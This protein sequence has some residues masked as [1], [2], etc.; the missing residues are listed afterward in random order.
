M[1][2]GAVTCYSKCYLRSTLGAGDRTQLRNRT[3]AQTQ[4]L[5]RI[6]NDMKRLFQIGIWTLTSIGCFGQPK[7]S[8]VITS[9][10]DI[11]RHLVENKSINGVEYEFQDR[12]HDSYLDTTS[13]TITL[14][15]RGLSKNGKWLD[16]KG[17]VIF[18]DL[19]ARKI[20]WRKTLNYNIT[21]IEQ[22]NSLIIETTAAKSYSL[23][24][25][26][27]SPQWEI[28]NS[29]YY[30]D[31]VNSIGLGYE[32]QNSVKKFSNTLKG[33]NLSNGAESWS[34]EIDREYGWN[35]VFHLNDSIL[36]IIS[37]GIH[38]VNLRNGKGWDY[39]TITG[40]KDYTGTAVANAA[41]VVLGVLTGTFVMTS[42]H[43]TVRSIVS[44]IVMDSSNFY[45]ASKEKVSCI[46]INTGRLRW[47]QPL[48]KDM[49]SK[50][51][52]FIKN[53]ILYLISRG[54]AYMGQRQIDYGKPFIAAFNI[55]DG[56]QIYFNPISSKE[57]INSFKTWGETISLVFKNSIMKYSLIDGNL[58]TLESY[59]PD[60]VGDLRYF[61]GRQVYISKDSLYK[62]LILSDTTKQFVFT[63]KGKTLILNDKLKI[64]GQIEFEDLFIHF[65]SFKGY[66]FLTRG[67][68][69]IILDKELKKVA[70]LDVGGN[71]MLIDRTLFEIKDK[72]IRR[73]DLNDV[74]RD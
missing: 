9:E 72:S 47:S 70:E 69:S 22:L 50:S 67:D 3:T 44:N 58:I 38:T 37:S 59:K 19:N 48:P 18:Y 27:G 64:E 13:N 43:N 23:S 24:I 53:D 14:Q 30:I 65:E 39:N 26:N 21:S 12:I 20:K 63:T 49:V 51:T 32:P 16:N 45:I 31:H 5:A 1:L 62:N 25:E 66:T 4:T 57:F 2:N 60:E 74:L 15:L 61:V 42:G 56:N 28:K 40:Q 35:E 73:I 46:E 55:G 11:G 33:I 71:C 7:T 36:V 41:G 34:R 17:D 8:E 6:N 29:I 52:L 54:Y 68:K 10:R